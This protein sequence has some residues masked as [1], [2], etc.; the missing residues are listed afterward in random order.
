MFW[1][2]AS[3]ANFPDTVTSWVGHFI[4]ILANA[5]PTARFAGKFDVSD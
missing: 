3:W 2:S 4:Y 1:C 5:F